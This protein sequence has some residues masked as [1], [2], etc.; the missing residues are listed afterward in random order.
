MYGSEREVMG[1]FAFLEAMMGPPPVEDPNGTHKHECAD[2]GTVWE[3]PDSRGGDEEAHTCPA[4]KVMM[5]PPW[6]KYFGEVVPTYKE[7]KKTGKPY[8]VRKKKAPALPM[9][10]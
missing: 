9:A 7:S 3:H 4:C 2:C 10:A 5:A 8:K 1:F 6:F